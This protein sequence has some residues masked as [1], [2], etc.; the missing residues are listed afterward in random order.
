MQLSGQRRRLLTMEGLQP[1][2]HDEIV[3]LAACI[4]G[5]DFLL[6][7]ITWEAVEL[8]PDSAHWVLSLDDGVGKVTSAAGQDI[9]VR[10]L[11]DWHVLADPHGKIYVQSERIAPQLLSDAMSQRKVYYKTIDVVMGGNAPVLKFHVKCFSYDL[12]PEG[13]Q[14]MWE[15][16]RVQ[17]FIFEG[18][19]MYYLGHKWLHNTWRRLRDVMAL[20]QLPEHTLRKSKP[21][22]Q[23]NADT[24]ADDNAEAEATVSTYGLLLLLSY[25][26]RQLA[27][28]RRER[29]FCLLRCL[30]A[31][32]S[33][34][35]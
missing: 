34:A 26:S 7:R 32:F 11:F 30:I 25:W 33:R 10:D 2:R 5:R 16:R 27:E 1:K 9:L 8:E 13:G 21:T 3:S 35:R 22:K 15:I 18:D 4:D 6:N 14:V 23:A 20:L 24:I 12:W 28:H 19:S 29:A 17:A 31:L